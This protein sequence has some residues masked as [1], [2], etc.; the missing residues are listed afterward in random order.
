MTITEAPTVVW[1]TV[2]AARAAADDRP[3]SRRRIIVRVLALTLVVAVVLLLAGGLV[4]KRLAEAEEVGG[5]AQRAGILAVDVAE[6]ALRDGVATGDPA[7]LAHL[8]AVVRAHVLGPGIARVKVWRSDGTI[9]YSDERRLIGE[10]FALE[11]DEREALEGDGTE[12]D[13]SDLSAPENRYDRGSGPLLEVY[14]AVH[15]PNGTPLLFETYFK[16]DDVVARSTSLWLG[17]AGITAASLLLLL[18]GLLPLLRGLV[19]ALER[20]REQRELLLLRALDASDAERRRIAALLHDGPVQDLVGAGYHLGAAAHAVRGTAA[21]A[22]LEA[23]ET[24]VRGTVQ[25]LRALLVDIY[26]ATLTQSG[27]AAGLEDLA[28]GARGRG[29]A[30]TIRVDPDARLS[31]DGDRVVFRVARE[32]LANAVKHGAGAPVSV[33]VAAERGRTVLTVHDDG[34]GFDAEALLERPRTA[35]FGLRL[36]RDAVTDGGVD[37]ELAVRSAPGAGTTWRLTVTA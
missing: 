25:S 34:P 29:T 4:A 22:T 5:A 13:I 30:V 1:R 2:A 19:R 28:A 11:A 18:L 24:T 21:E 23:A 17:F 36:L 8:D 27:L 20:A 31:A 14:R 7:A 15:T 35:H 3:V 37:A 16:Y 9:V 12:A 10:R 32:A 26:P 6:P 33:V